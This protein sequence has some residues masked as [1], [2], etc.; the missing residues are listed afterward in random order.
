MDDILSTINGEVDKS[1]YKTEGLMYCGK[2]NTPKEF[3]I[4]GVARPIRCECAKKAQEDAERESLERYTQ[5]SIRDKIRESGIESKYLKSVWDDIVVVKGNEEPLKECRYW[6][7][8]FEKYSEDGKGLLFFGGVGTGKTMIASII[9]LELLRQRKTVLFVSVIDLMSR[10]TG[11]EYQ[12][13]NERFNNAV[14][15]CGLLILDDLGA[16]RST[17]YAKERVMAVLN[18]R[19]VSGK[20]MI[21]TTNL[22]ADELLGTKDIES[23]RI[24]DRCIETCFSIEFKGESYRKTISKNDRSDFKKAVQGEYI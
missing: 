7:D 12:E 1:D 2:C 20:P 21:V 10:G 18:T 19:Y 15:N 22:T 5:T 16:E 14:K 17:S 4:D 11:Y 6:L 3:M 13:E 23:K 8:H 9:G 24:V